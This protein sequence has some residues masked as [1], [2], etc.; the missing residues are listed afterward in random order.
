[1]YH[2]HVAKDYS[3]P[4]ITEEIMN[5]E[6]SYLARLLHSTPLLIGLFPFFGWPLYIFFGQADGNHFIP[7][8]G[9]LWKDTP[10]IEQ[11]KGII[12]SI[13]VVLA[14]FVVYR[15]F[16][17]SLANCAFYYLGPWVIFTWWLI[18]VTYLQ[19][20]DPD[21]LVYDD[22]DWT[23]VDAAFETVDRKYGTIIDT[24]SHHITDGHVIH[25]L[26]FTKIP[27]YNLPKA[28]KALQNFLKERNLFHKY[29]YEDSWN[30]FYLLHKFLI[31]NGFRAVLAADAKRD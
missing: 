19:H 9:R 18:C 28:T 26:F 6:G 27:H 24:L 21:T 1:M 15:V 4:W 11:I 30:Y 3:Y 2:N 17:P 8:F 7:I 10:Y 20:H 13:V 5:D 22:K 31:T 25:H 23:F 12:S 14:G 16:G 29:R